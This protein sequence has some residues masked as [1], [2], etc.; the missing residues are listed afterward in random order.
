MVSDFLFPH[1]ARAVVRPLAARAGA[2]VLLQVLSGDDADP[3]VGSAFRLTDSESGETLDHGPG[4]PCGRRIQ[5]AHKAGSAR[6]CTRS[7][8]A[9]VGGG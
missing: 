6:R 9:A 3:Q 4:V 2:F 1:S 5:G 7:V 8:G